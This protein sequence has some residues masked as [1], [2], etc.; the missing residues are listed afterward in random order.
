MKIKALLVAGVCCGIFPE[1]AFA[2]S[3]EN[4]VRNGD[5]NESAKDW[6]IG[7]REPELGSITFEIENGPE[8][9]GFVRLA[10]LNSAAPR[11]LVLQ[12][13]FANPPVAGQYRLRA[14]IRISEDYAA[15]MPRVSFGWRNPGDEGETGSASLQLDQ[16]AAPGE[17]IL[18][19]EE[20]EI[21]EGAEGTYVFIFTYGSMGHADF[22]GIS[23]ER[24]P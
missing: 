3:S 21:P 6:E 20:M 1:C 24:L 12:Q 2:Q 5:F 7:Y 15:K 17:W 23:L 9:A 14:W 11:Y 13:K 22:G 8:G 19:E 16:A 18:C 4:L 10:P